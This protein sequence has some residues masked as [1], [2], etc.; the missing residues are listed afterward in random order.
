MSCGSCCNNNCCCDD[1][2][3]RRRSGA[4]G[5]TGATGAT[6]PSGGGGSGT[7][8]A[9]GATGAAGGGPTPAYIGATNTGLLEIAVADPFTFDTVEENDGITYDGAGG[10][11]VPADGVYAV[12]FIAQTAAVTLLGGVE[13]AVDDVPVGDPE[14]LLLVGA[15][16][17]LTRLVSVSAGGVISVRATGL[18]LTLALVGLNAQITIVR[19]A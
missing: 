11:V 17:S 18:A 2:G 4:R 6:G 7:T 5:P 19:V 1:D 15:S 16:L 9:T 10:F 13:L 14:S 12:N 3:G 8:G